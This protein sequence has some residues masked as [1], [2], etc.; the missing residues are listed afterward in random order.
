MIIL[1]LH[2]VTRFNINITTV[3]Q[4]SPN[5]VISIVQVNRGNKSLHTISHPVSQN[6]NKQRQ[7]PP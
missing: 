7:T 6:N 4:Y 1:I 3:T 2:Y 5:N